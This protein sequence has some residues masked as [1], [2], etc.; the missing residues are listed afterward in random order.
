MA[1]N[2]TVLFT[3]RRHVSTKHSF[4]NLIGTGQSNVI[5]LFENNV[6]IGTTA[7]RAK[8][9]VTG[10]IRFSGIM[11]DEDNNALWIP[12][13]TLQ[14]MDATASAVGVPAGAT[15]SNLE[16]KA[17]YRYI[18]NDVMYNF[19][20]NNK[21]TA[22]ASISTDNY[23]LTLPQPL[24]TASYATNSVIGD[25]M[26]SVTNATATLTTTYKAF[27]MVNA[28]N[29][30][31]T[32]RYLNG[33][34]DASLAEFPI[35]FTFR[36]QGTITYASP[37]TA[38]N[39]ALP[40][41]FLPQKFYT[42]EVG[43]VSFNT[44]SA[45]P[46]ARFDVGENSTLPTMKIT[47]SGTGDIVQV[48]D[49]GA[50][51]LVVK[52][53]GNVGIGTTTPQQ[54]LH[55]VGNAFIEGNLT[56]NGTQ[57]ITNNGTG[58]ALI[59]NQTGTEPVMEIQDA[60]VPVMKIIDGGNVGIGTTTPLQKLHVQGNILSSGTLTSTQLVSTVAA[61]TAPLAVT[62]T[63]LV[64]NLNT[65]L[66]NGQDGAYYLNYT[67]L[68]NT[69]A[70]GMQ[71]LTRGNYL[72]GNDYNGSAATSW[73]VDATTTA[74][75]SKVVARDAS[76]DDFRRNGNAEYL[77]MSH[78]AAAR[79][80][81]TVFYSSTDDFIR[82]NT[83]AG[84]QTALNV[85]T[86]TGDNASGTWNINISGTAAGSDSP[87]T[88]NGTAVY[89][90][91]TGNVGIGTT[92]P[93]TKLHVTGQARIEGQTSTF[94]YVISGHNRNRTYTVN[95][96][97]V[98]ANGCGLAGWDQ[99]FAINNTNG[100]LYTWGANTYG[101]LGN[102]T[103][104]QSLVPVNISTFGTL[105]GRTVVSA[106]GGGLA[107]FA[108]D[109]TGAVHAWGLNAQGSLGNN[110][111]TDRLVPVNVSTFGSLSGRTVV[112]VACGNGHTLAVDSTGTLHA[113]GFNNRGMVGNNST[114]RSLI[115]INISS[116]GSLSGRTIVAAAGGTNHTVA[117]DNTGAVH[118]WG[119]G[120]NGRL[121]RNSTTNS[122][123][124]VNVSSFGS[125][126][127]RT[128][129]AVAIGFDNTLALDNTGA[130][131]TWGLNTNG[132]LG[133]NSTSEALVPINVSSFGSLS[134]R[135]VVAAAAGG[136]HMVALDSTGA[137]HTW[138]QND[139]G[140]LGNNST[141]ASGSRIPVNISTLGSLSGRTVV[142]VGSGGSHA[143]AVDSTGA[144]HTWGAGVNGR[145]GINSTTNSRIPVNVSLLPSSYQT[146]LGIGMTPTY[147][148][149]L[150]TDSAAKPS[151]STWTVSSDER[152]KTNIEVADYDRCYE[153]V[154]KLDLKSYNWNS[155]NPQ[156]MQSVG[157]DHHRLG[158][159]A[160]EI[161]PIFPKAVSIVPELYGVSN[162][163][164]VNFDQ[165]YAVQYGAVK[166]LIN[167]VTAVE[168]AIND[169]KA[170]I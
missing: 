140:Q 73:S 127:G 76:G 113:W 55:V 66:L 117:L 137:V 41:A 105:S 33:T 154:S 124:P 88:T 96:I 74:T 6:G 167:K 131:H 5:T 110:S 34:T 12:G 56:V 121:G 168:Q 139:L 78:A 44:G 28:D 104:T 13:S 84:M 3:E 58:A 103:T 98:N 156:L 15:L 29:T 69:S 151:T 149:Q 35:N 142:A 97:V 134:G 47:Q 120:A 48:L 80:T 92:N 17:T 136:T 125:L 59:V 46:S 111:T 119:N 157:S 144:V 138:G 141:T 30:R 52:D 20:T 148:L 106:A 123:I 162:V 130:V 38:N 166:K 122:L 129:V 116:F 4:Y 155:N 150:S 161:E 68:T 164:N 93:L 53:G 65:A 64:P 169:I 126:S 91:N 99:T 145:L 7:L 85:P 54:K 19:N 23:T 70:D 60:G 49:S 43:H 83:Q 11:Y 50:S 25:L 67:N 81:D 71:T 101:Q 112:A 108:L 128:V 152:L 82:K 10:D 2:N 135:T 62:S 37:S 95:S 102:N 147:Q 118:T 1:T 79:T 9:D 27:A 114:T 36:L 14:W 100:R 72:T 22:A 115:P 94:K 163:L 42:D 160:Q 21:I 75:D 170:Q 51:A 57:T 158:W 146:A 77:V 165:L 24:K 90:N 87:W 61:G 16:A 18:G 45:A 89:A 159:I 63:T 39:L 133:N 109:S 40:S 8:L 86:R 26:L 32:L 143:V 31:V 107:M 153:I 132:A